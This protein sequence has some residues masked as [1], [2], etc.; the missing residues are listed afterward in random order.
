MPGQAASDTCQIGL[1][2][3]AF[4]PASGWAR[5][6]MATALPFWPIWNPGASALPPSLREC[7]RMARCATCLRAGKLYPADYPAPGGG[8][9]LADLATSWKRRGSCGGYAA[10]LKD[11]GQPC[12]KE[13]SMAKLF[14]PG[15][16]RAGGSG[17][18]Q[19]LGGYGY[20]RDF[21]IERI[22]TRRAVTVDLRRHQRYSALAISRGLVDGLAAVGSANPPGRC[23]R[24]AKTP[25]TVCVRLA[26][27]AA[28]DL[29]EQR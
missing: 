1:T 13:A 20:L 3:A 27:S 12:L 5:R 17:A 24:P 19:T 10:S 15:N 11:A 9:R 23:S 16:G 18:L 8:L 21:P 14:A 4:P 7:G 28:L 25:R 26:R 6:A 22:Y 2:S 29:G